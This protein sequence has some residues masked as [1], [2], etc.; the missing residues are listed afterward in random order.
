MSELEPI[1]REEILLNS[2]AEGEASGLTPITRQENYLAAIAGESELPDD[3]T[4]IT[5]E[6]IYLNAI[7]SRIDKIS[8]PTQEQIDVAVNNYFEEQGIDALFIDSADIP[9]VLEE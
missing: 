1:T 8:T 3:M 6:E 9:E 7:L 5:R 2:I 4:P